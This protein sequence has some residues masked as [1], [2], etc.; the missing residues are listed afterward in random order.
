MQNSISTLLVTT[1]FT[2]KSKNALEM[3]VHIALR[4]HSRIIILHNINHFFVIDKTGKQLL[5]ADVVKNNVKRVEKTFQKMKTSLVSEYPKLV[6]ETILTSDTLINGINKVID[7]EDVDLVVC[8]TSGKQDF[9]RVVIGSL[10]YEILTGVNT[11][12]LLVP[13]SCTKYT[14]EKILVPVRVTDNLSDK[15]DLS[16]TIAK[17]NKGSIDILGISKEDNVN[18]IGKAYLDVRRTLEYCSQRYDSH[19]VETGDNALQI[20]EYSKDD[21]ADIII[22]NY[23]DEQSWKSIFMENF[24]KQIINNTVVPLFFLKN[25]YEKKIDSTKVGDGYDVLLPHPG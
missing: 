10:S 1:D 20:S 18:T 13:E 16:L 19:F 11:S 5:G 8:G 3:A 17:K 21:G 15:I 7:D 12:V 6:I 14:F 9:I 22:L 2:E 4:H 24:F 23:Q 25:R